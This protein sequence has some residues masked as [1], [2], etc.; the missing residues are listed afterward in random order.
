M[1][2]VIFINIGPI[3]NVEEIKS[4]ENFKNGEKL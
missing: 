3:K 1:V 4:G 2:F